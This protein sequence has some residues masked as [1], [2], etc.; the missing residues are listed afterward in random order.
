MIK[1]N[2]ITSVILS[3]RTTLIDNT[4]MV[5]QTDYNTQYCV[6]ILR[7]VNVHVITVAKKG[8]SNRL[9][10]YLYFDSRCHTGRLLFSPSKPAY[11][12]LLLILLDKHHIFLNY[13]TFVLSKKSIKLT[14]FTFIRKQKNHVDLLN[15]QILF[16]DTLTL[17]ASCR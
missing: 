1:A 15:S 9:S 8:A 5:S 12:K 4:F 6:I 11:I 3:R 16:Y 14:C 2:V 17:A 7:K 13:L 10:F